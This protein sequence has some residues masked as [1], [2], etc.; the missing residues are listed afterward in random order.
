MLVRR[1]ALGAKFRRQHPAGPYV[2]DFY[3][4]EHRLAVELDGSPHW[5]GDAPRR[6]A[7]RTAFLNARGIRVLR[8]TNAEM[9]EE[10]DAVI[11]VIR[12]AMGFLDE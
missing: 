5:W 12:E 4:P 11:R 10:Q 7:A 3:C 2:L 1:G 6:G 8:F 9:L